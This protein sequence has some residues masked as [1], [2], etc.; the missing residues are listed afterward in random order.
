MSLPVSFIR[1]KTLIRRF[2]QVDVFSQIGFYG[3]PVAV[4][5]DGDG[6]ST[7]D[8][9]RFARWTNLSETTFVCSAT[10]P[11]ADYLLRIFTPNFELP[12]AGHPTLG[13]AYAV[14]EAGRVA[15]HDG[16]LVQQ[17]K[18]GLVP[19]FVPLDWQDEGLSFRM[20]QHKIRTAPDPNALIAAMRCQNLKREAVCVDVGPQWVI[21]ELETPDAVA[22]LKPDLA[23]LADYDRHHGTTGL[24][25]FAEASGDPADIV[26]R[27]FAPLD[28]IAEDPVC[29]SG[30]GSVAAFRFDNGTAKIGTSYRASQGRE[31][32]RNGIVNIRYGT[33]GIHIGGH[34]TSG[35]DGTV[36][37]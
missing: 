18:L 8:M 32:G 25:V 24:T 10:T 1:A 16:G 4:V 22:C 7:P 2:K 13:S 15:P 37:L 27:S 14:L 34:C 26:V 23:A 28:G 31:I 3:N 20:P 30:N 9:Q 6:L 5:L 17:C 36:M 29:G 33:D 12:F 35:I 21:A 19:V 11:D